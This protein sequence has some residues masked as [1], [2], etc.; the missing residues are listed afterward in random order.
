MWTAAFWKATAERA[1]KTF[2]QAS[3]AA[4]GVGAVNLASVGWLPALTLAGVATLLSVLSSLGSA[5]VGDS[6]P[7]LV[8][9]DP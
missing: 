3:L 1:V 6:S 4:L 2:A 9:V 7:S 8:K 5:K